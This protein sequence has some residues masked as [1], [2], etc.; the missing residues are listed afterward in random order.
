MSNLIDMRSIVNLYLCGVALLEQHV[1]DL[2]GRA[3]AKQLPQRLLVP[4]YSIAIDKCDEVIRRVSRQ[5]RTSKVWILRHKVV[6]RHH[7]VGEV[8]ATTT[9]DA[10]LLSSCRITFE[11]SHTLAPRGSMYCAKEPCGACA[12]DDDVVR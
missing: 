8:A 6:M 12:D 9:G 4:C 1:D 11:N 10:N 5:C 2:L 3:I 7:T